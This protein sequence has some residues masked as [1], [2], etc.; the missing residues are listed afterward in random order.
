MEDLSK[1]EIM[2]DDLADVVGGVRWS[3]DDMGPAYKPGDRVVSQSGL[4]G[5]I[6]EAFTNNYFAGDRSGNTVWYKCIMDNQEKLSYPEQ[7]LTRI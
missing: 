2:D 7:K 1:F 3:N 6:V 5:T 4:K